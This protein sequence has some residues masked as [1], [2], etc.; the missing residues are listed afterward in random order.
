MRLDVEALKHQV[1]NQSHRGDGLSPPENQVPQNR[2]GRSM[3]EDKVGGRVEGRVEEGLSIGEGGAGAGG[4]HAGTGESRSELLEV[5]TVVRI[6]ES[7]VRV[8]L[9]LCAPAVTDLPSII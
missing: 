7:A 3:Y 2:S 4:A 8:F 5:G 9:S 1:S 6:C